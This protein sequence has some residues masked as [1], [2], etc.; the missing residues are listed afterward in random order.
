VADNGMIVCFQGCDEDATMDEY[1]PPVWPEESGK[2]QKQMQFIYPVDDLQS[3]VE[4]A[5]SLGAIK[6][7]KQYGGK[8][9]VTL[10]DPDGH[11]FCLCARNK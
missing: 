8:Q 2:Q 11:P 9:W 7:D 6:P 10:L 3:S 1:L 4:E 5:I